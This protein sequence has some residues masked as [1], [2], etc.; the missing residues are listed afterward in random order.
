V[1]HR[2]VQATAGS[3]EDSNSGQKAVAVARI[4]AVDEDL[5]KSERV[6][7]F[8]GVPLPEETDE[9]GLDE[10]QFLD[11]DALETLLLERP[12][13]FFIHR[14]VAISD[15]TVLAVV[16][17]T[18]E[19]SGGHFPGRPI[20]PLIELCKAMAQA[21]II[22]VALR[23]RPGE[24]PIAISSGPSKALAKELIAAP[25]DVLI[26]VTLDSSRLKLHF[27]NGS[28]FVAGKKIGTLASIV[29]TLVPKAFLL[30]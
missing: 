3:E 12:P 20:V 16:R 19:R 9:L 17:M 1:S 25:V 14:A 26:K 7:E 8:L 21:G 10:I 5:F 30:G 6:A 18:A 11:S 29:Y 24:A 2:A 4:S 28:A 22:L 27:V 15:R 23:A 13:F